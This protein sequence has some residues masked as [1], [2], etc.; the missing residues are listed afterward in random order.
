MWFHILGPSGHFL[1]SQCNPSGFGN[2]FKFFLY[3]PLPR[4]LWNAAPK[5]VQSAFPS[6]SLRK[7]E[8]KGDKTCARG[9]GSGIQSCLFLWFP[10]SLPL[11]SISTVLVDRANCVGKQRLSSWKHSRKHPRARRTSSFFC[12]VLVHQTGPLHWSSTKL[13]TEVREPLERQ[14]EPCSLHRLLS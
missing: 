3:F 10:A 4:L 5:K 14:A 7:R 2:E 12:L 13:C 1:R 9:L 6:R 11:S 8:N